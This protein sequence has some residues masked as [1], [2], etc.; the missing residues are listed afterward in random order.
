MLYITK[1][2]DRISTH[3]HAHTAHTK[4]S[5]SCLPAEERIE[6][7]SVDTSVVLPGGEKRDA[8]GEVD[9]ADDDDD[10]DDDDEEEGYTGRFTLSRVRRNSRLYTRVEDLPGDGRLTL[11]SKPLC[12]EGVEWSGVMWWLGGRGRVSVRME[13]TVVTRDERGNG[14]YQDGGHPGIVCS[15]GG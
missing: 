6:K 3:I 4:Q 10:D 13:K 9:A 14:A 5:T 11:I 15:A 2:I 8:V 7:G 12:A 1:L